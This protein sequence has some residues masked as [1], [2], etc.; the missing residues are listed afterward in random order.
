V[1]RAQDEQHDAP[2]RDPTAVM[3]RRVVAFLIDLV[4]PSLV[5]VLTFLV[6]AEQQEVPAFFDDACDFIRAESDV[7]QCFQSG[8]HVYYLT[9]RDAAVV[10]LLWIGV[11][12]M[13]DVV[14]QGVAGASVGKIITGL[15]VVN[16]D[17]QICGIGRA[18]VRWVLLIVDALVCF[19]IGLLTALTSRGH[20]RVGDMVA[21]TYVVDAREVGLR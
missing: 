10:Y 21:N 9:N 8:N 2:L 6:L 13:N 20:R 4:V 14:L 11:A 5:L 1:A 15:R 17:G 19:L 3:G 16:A 7:S 12:F 18:T